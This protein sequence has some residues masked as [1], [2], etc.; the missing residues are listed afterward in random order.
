MNI[1]WKGKEIEQM[2]GYEYLSTVVNKHGTEEEEINN[3]IS[4]A[5]Q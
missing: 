3:K 2:A 5:N 4:K 1:L